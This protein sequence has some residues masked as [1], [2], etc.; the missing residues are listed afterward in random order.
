M[1]AEMGWLRVF[2]GWLQMAGLQQLCTT[3]RAGAVDAQQ[4]RKSQRL[5]ESRSSGPIHH[6]V[7]RERVSSSS[8]IKPSSFTLPWVRFQSCSNLA[9]VCLESKV[10]FALHMKKI[11]HM[12]FINSVPFQFSAIF[13]APRGA[14]Y[15]TVKTP[16]H[17]H[18]LVTFRFAIETLVFVDSADTDF[19]CFI[20][21]YFDSIYKQ[22][23][24][25]SVKFF[26]LF[27]F[28]NK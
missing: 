15:R 5:W 16:V 27:F 13:T 8:E 23:F 7:C 18:G 9:L 2:G 10:N 20:F 24:F 4:L 19:C 1:C 28:F 11:L 22:K 17:Q 3:K 6:L 21:W 12:V 25:L 14:L 26:F